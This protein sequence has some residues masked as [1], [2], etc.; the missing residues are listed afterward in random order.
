MHAANSPLQ[1]RSVVWPHLPIIWRES[2]KDKLPNRLRNFCCISFQR[3]QHL[4]LSTYAQSQ[5]AV[6]QH[7]IAWVIVKPSNSTIYQI[8][9]TSSNREGSGPAL[10]EICYLLEANSKKF[11]PG[12]KKWILNTAGRWCQ[13]EAAKKSQKH[14]LKAVKWQSVWGN[15]W[16]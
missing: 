13:L 12:Q 11:S 2:H 1:C 6:S 15:E 10:T 5:T 16:R 4:S 7:R 3:F 14:H 8:P 9:Y